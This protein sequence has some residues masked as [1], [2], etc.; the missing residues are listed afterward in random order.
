M[1]MT[2]RTQVQACQLGHIV[3]IENQ[4]DGKDFLPLFI[5]MYFSFYCS[6][7]KYWSTE[8]DQALVILLFFVHFTVS[9][10]GND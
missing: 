4:I 7:H 1:V 3:K 8:G 9:R 2:Y 5:F 10:S 6:S